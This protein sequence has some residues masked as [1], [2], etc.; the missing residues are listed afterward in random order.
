MKYI[1][2]IQT[3]YLIDFVEQVQK[4]KGECVVKLNDYFFKINGKIADIFDIVYYVNF[5]YNHLPNELRADYA[6]AWNQYCDKNIMPNDQI[7]TKKCCKLPTSQQNEQQ[8]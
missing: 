5:V 2:K 4:D 8:F 1:N 6:S 7:L 3:K